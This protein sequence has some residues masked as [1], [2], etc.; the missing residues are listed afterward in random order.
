[1]KKVCTIIVTYNRKQLL[2]NLLEALA[3]STYNINSIIIVDN[4]STDGT[5]CFLQERNIISGASEG[6]VTKN[7]WKGIEINYFLNTYNAGGSGGF[8]KAFSLV[9]DYDVDFVWAM[10]DDV[11]PDKNCL[12]QMIEC[13]DEKCSMVIPNRSSGNFT[14]YA[15]QNYNLTNP[16]LFHI[17]QC[18]RNM[19]RGADLREKYVRVED[20]AFEGPLMTMNLIQ[21]VGIPNADYFIMFDDTDYAHRAL[22]YTEIRFAK[23]AHLNK[24]IT[25]LKGPKWTWKTYYVVRNATYF[26]RSYGQNAMVRNLR[27]FL[28]W[29]DLLIRACLKGNF[30]RI[31]WLNKAYHDGIVGCMGK[32]AE[33]SEIPKE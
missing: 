29:C 30:Y 18:K 16:F 22:K 9:L 28:R 1:M 27:P 2:E 15:I 5:A 4:K 10:D 32:T 12:S 21:K 33:P 6:K 20:M 19:I 25:P 31:K 3:G 8:A 11:L 24:Q 23:D 13:I 7:L 17:N 14:D 26:D